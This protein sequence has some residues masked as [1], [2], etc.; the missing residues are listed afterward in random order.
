MMYGNLDNF[1]P[2]TIAKKLNDK[3]YTQDFE[4]GFKY[5]YKNDTTL[6]RLCDMGAYDKEYCGESLPCP[7][8]Y[9]VMDW[10]VTEKHIFIE[11]SMAF[12]KFYVKSVSTN[13]FDETM[14]EQKLLHFNPTDYLTVADSVL[15]EIDY[16]ITN[17]I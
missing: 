8:I 7:R 14:G 10:L 1:V 13:E 5:I 2:Y 11:M 6:L 9:Q 3:G 16:I 15:H 4:D 12:N 17:L